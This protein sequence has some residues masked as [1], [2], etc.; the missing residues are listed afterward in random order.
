[1]SKSYKKSYE[2]AKQKVHIR[3]TEYLKDRSHRSF[4]VTK[5]RDYIQPLHL[6]GYIA[7]T[8]YVNKT[9]ISSKSMFFRLALLYAVL[10]ALLV[11]IAS[12]ELYVT[13]S[14]SLRDTSGEIFSGSFG[15]I[16]EA[17][18][19][20]I[21]GASGGINQ[22]LTEAQQIFALLISLLIWLST[23]WFLRNKL[24][25]NKVNLRDVVYSS[26]APLV[27]TMFILL[28]AALQLLP[29]AVGFVVY[30]AASVS[31]LLEGGVEAMLAWMG[32]GMLSVLSL[33]WLTSTFMSLIVVTLPGMYPMKAIRTGADI[34]RGRRLRVL[35]RVLWMG[36]VLVVSWLA[37]MVPVIIFDTWL[38][39]LLPAIEWLPFV[40]VVLLIVTSM[41]VVWIASYVYLLYR[42]IVEDVVSQTA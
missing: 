5:R 19:L 33:Y 31:G 42:K 23:V 14:D 17:T 16:G 18:L 21:A 8:H 41:S 26:S 15:Q 39:G 10:T 4:R 38:K 28:L 2:S 22:N 27:S 30:S 32:I 25:G 1:M 13:I 6:P 35:Y 24:S 7:F 36:L 40:P 29:L 11:G 20:F 34:V 37:I 9:I 12:Q 3:K